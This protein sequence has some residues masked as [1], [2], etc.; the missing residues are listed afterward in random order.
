MRDPSCCRR[1]RPGRHRVPPV[2]GRCVQRKDGSRGPQLQ[3]HDFGRDGDRSI[4]PVPARPPAFC[5]VT[6]WAVPLNTGSSKVPRGTAHKA[7]QFGGLRTSVGQTLWDLTP[8]HGRRGAGT[9]HARRYTRAHVAVPHNPHAYRQ[10]PAARCLSLPCPNRSQT[11]GPRRS[12]FQDGL[13]QHPGR[14][15]ATAPLG[16][17]LH[18]YSHP[19]GFTRRDVV[20]EVEGNAHLGLALGTH[21]TRRGVTT[22]L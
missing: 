3:R 16:D 7:R 9:P 2:P 18:R 5:P 20:E 12:S 11:G 22:L 4:V 8:P 13:G 1:G 14:A 6:V 19:A 15:A 17:G 10:A 21:S